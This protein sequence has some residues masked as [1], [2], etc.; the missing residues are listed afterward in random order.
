MLEAGLGAEGATSEEC[1]VRGLVDGIT[2]ERTCVP[3]LLVFAL[4]RTLKLT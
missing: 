1:I 4:V 3:V 2:D